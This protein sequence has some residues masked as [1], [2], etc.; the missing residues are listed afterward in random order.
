[1]DRR[2]AGLS[3]GLAILLLPAGAVAEPVRLTIGETII[4]LD[5]ELPVLACAVV[6]T[7]G[8]PETDDRACDAARAQR[9]LP[10][11]TMSFRPDAEGRFVSCAPHPRRAPSPEF[12]A[13]CAAQLARI[14]NMRAMVPIEPSSWISQHDQASALRSSP[15]IV[16]RIGIDDRGQPAFCQIEGPNQSRARA[17]LCPQIRRRARFHPARDLQGRPMPSVYRRSLTAAE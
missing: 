1:M 15:R 9:G 6:R 7:S 3:I 14:G 4:Q 16:I 17:K 8:D 5:A 13:A 2:V 11:P 10:E 12:E